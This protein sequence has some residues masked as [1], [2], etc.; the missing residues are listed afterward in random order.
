MPR[1]AD[2]LLLIVILLIVW[3][4]LA[5][6]LTAWSMWFQGFLYTEPSTGLV[7]RGPAA[8]SAI[9]AVVLVW[10]VLDYRTEGRYR[11]IWET[12]STETTKAFTELRVP[13]E[14]GR[15]EVYKLRPGTRHEYRLE[16]LPSG[17][18]MP[19]TPPVIIAV[20]GEERHVFKPELD[21]K[22]NYLRRQAGRGVQEPLRY[23]DEKGRVMR[24]DDL[25]RL[26]TFRT[27]TFLGNLLVN[28]V[29]L[30]VCFVAFWLL[31]R[32]QWLHALGHA[33]ALALLMMLFVLPPVLSYAERTAAAR[34]APK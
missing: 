25:G 14:A 12:S 8:A 31:A 19:A 28:V 20:E 11:P 34:A 32:F 29:F 24:E 7:W 3:V 1:E 16:G 5:I 18:P 6:L 26:E 9:M 30:A 17:R 13:D 4:V 22:G 27:G 21:P 2:V 10:V 23:V 15:E 33:V